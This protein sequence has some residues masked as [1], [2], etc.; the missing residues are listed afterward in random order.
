MTAC[1]EQGCDFGSIAYATTSVEAGARGPNVLILPRPSGRDANGFDELSL[2]FPGLLFP[3]TPQ[4]VQNARGVLN[5]TEWRDVL[6]AV[7]AALGC[8]RGSSKDGTERGIRGVVVG[9]HANISAR[10]PLLTRGIVLTPEPYSFHKDAYFGVVPLY[11]DVK[12]YSAPD[13]LVE[14]GEWCRAVTGGAQSVLVAVTDVM[15]VRR[16]NLVGGPPH[17]ACDDELMRAVDEGLLQW[18]GCAPVGAAD[19]GDVADGADGASAG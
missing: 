2:V 5:D 7:P 6:A 8:H 15:M 19:G 1:G 14:A 10:F 11:P 9:F 3:V 4:L 13:F 17:S 18:L 12:R 16:A